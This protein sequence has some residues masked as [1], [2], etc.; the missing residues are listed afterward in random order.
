MW[1]ATANSADTMSEPLL[2]RFR[3]FH[4]DAPDRS[5]AAHVCQSVYRSL[6]ESS[7]W[8]SQFPESLTVDVVSELATLT[9]RE[10]MRSLE[11]AAGRAV[12]SGRTSIS[13]EDI[14]VAEP[15]RSSPGIG[16]WHSGR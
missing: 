11:E 13:K 16:F 6:R 14:H 10:V 12:L 9:P 7:D 3:V 5:Q 1:V 8:G 15:H 4:V 2:S